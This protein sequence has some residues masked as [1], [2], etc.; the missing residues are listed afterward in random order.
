M[1]KPGASD[2]VV[3]VRLPGLNLSYPE[4]AIVD[5]DGGIL[6]ANALGGSV[7][8]VDH[9]GARPI[10]TNRRDE[11]GA[12]SIFADIRFSSSG[13][14][15][16]VDSSANEILELGEGYEVTRVIPGPDLG[17]GLHFISSVDER[18]GQILVA[19]RP[20][21]QHGAAQYVSTGESALFLWD[22]LTWSVLVTASGIGD[23][24]ASFRDA[25]YIGDGHIA[26][27]VGSEFVLLDPE[28]KIE[29][30][31]SIGASNGGGIVEM[32]EGFLVGSYTNL[33]SVNRETFTVTPVVFPA[34]FANV[35]HLH[36]T[37]NGRLLVTDTD[38]QIVYVQD[39]TTGDVV[40]QIGNQGVP[41]KVV[42]LDV[43]GN[44]LLMLE[45][46]SPRVLEYHPD[47]GALWV[48]AGKGEQG[49]DSPGRAAN[50][51]FQYP[52]GMTS[53]RRGS[54]FV[55]EANYRIA[56]V[57]GGRV[58]IF[59]GSINAGRPDD[60]QFRTAAGFGGLRGMDVGPE[61]DLFVA[62][63]GNHSIWRIDAQ[64]AVTLVM[65][66]GEP[67]VWH[68]GRSAKT[69]PLN[70]PSGVLARMD[71]SILI[72][73]SYNNTV[74]EVTAGGIVKPFAGVPL[75][76]S[77]QGLGHYS[78]D[79]GHA[80]AA[81][82]NTPRQMAEDGAGNVYIVD[83]FNNAVRKVTSDGVISTFAGG[84]FGF[85]ESGTHM[86]LPQ[87]AAVLGDF[88][89]VADTGN[90]VVRAFPLSTRSSN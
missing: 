47:S 27:V 59:A 81:Q 23:G 24:N 29:G 39:T 52:S 8:L 89:Y 35:G 22:G 72:A 16:V 20:S 1:A 75:A 90:S 31:A 53:D 10:L 4:A 70:T 41:L 30:R 58:D 28:G 19:A 51:K 40:E 48:M 7:I 2:P 65:G 74:V 86:N 12:S 17:H 18:A 87:S 80:I 82:L 46:S 73:D 13:E 33:L 45:N 43:F 3:V 55:S 6:V 26:A 62:D 88:L 56:Q 21:R 78:G 25:V 44:S 34:P 67:G 66:T 64:G 15:L 57:A 14:L 63:Q 85:S 79:G 71:G 77:Y 36:L 54:I 38:R 69:Q 37:G 32:G 61:G 49:Y 84:Q 50:F 42:S 68:D 76:T 9:E 11:T 60:G 5:P 83:E